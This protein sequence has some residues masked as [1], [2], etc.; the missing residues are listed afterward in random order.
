MILQDLFVSTRA[1]TTNMMISH[2]LRRFLRRRKGLNIK[3]QKA[4]QCLNKEA[5]K[6]SKHESF[7]KSEIK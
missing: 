6:L 3:I 7:W 4:N 1:T 5:F 2:Q